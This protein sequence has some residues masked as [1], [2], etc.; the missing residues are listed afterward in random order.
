MKEKRV[1]FQGVIKSVK[2][3]IDTVG[4]KIGTLTVTFRP[5]GNVIA[6]LDALH[7]PDSEIFVVIAAKAE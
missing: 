2:T 5:E 3:A 7:K 6:D 1:A 4:D